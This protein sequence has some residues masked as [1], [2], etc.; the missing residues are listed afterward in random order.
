LKTQVSWK[1]TLKSKRNAKHDVE[2]KILNHDQ[3]VNTEQPAKKSFQEI[4]SFP[5]SLEISNFQS[6]VNSKNVAWADNLTIEVSEIAKKYDDPI[7]N[8]LVVHCNF[9]E[10]EV[11]SDYGDF[12]VVSIFHDGIVDLKPSSIEIQILLPRLSFFRYYLDLI[13]LKSFGYLGLLKFFG[14]KDIVG[15]YNVKKAEGP[16]AQGWDVLNKGRDAVLKFKHPKGT[17]SLPVNFPNI[18]FYYS[19]AAKPLFIFFSAGF[20]VIILHYLISLLLKW[21]S[22]GH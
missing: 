21:T 8:P 4:I 12:A 19:R 17:G 11:I 5:S 1:I 22:G 15:V 20:S 18:N 6:V 16:D 2:I 3:P 13:L 7:P 9:D 14:I 10:E